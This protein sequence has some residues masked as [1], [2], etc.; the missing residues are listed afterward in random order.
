MI[1]SHEHRFIFVKTRKTAGTSIEVLLARALEPGAV[2]TPIET[3]VDGHA[4][5]NFERPPRTIASARSRFTVA[6]RRDLARDRWFFNHMPASLIRDRLGP[7]VWRSYFKFAFERDPWDKTVSWYF[8]RTRNL[9]ERPSFAEFVTEWRLPSDWPKYT[10]DDELA[11]DFV[12]RFEHLDADLQHALDQIG[13][14]TVGA[15]P[16]EKSGLRPSA[17]R[18]AVLHDAATTSRVAEVFHH[19]IATFG[20]AP[21]SP[22]PDTVSQT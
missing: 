7:K 2:V 9:A 18:A 19:E 21:P 11:V 14:T 4:P 20:Y 10:I 22:A 17:A 8:Y 16:Q 12:G 1:V 5:R 3:P 6:G 13:L 15:L